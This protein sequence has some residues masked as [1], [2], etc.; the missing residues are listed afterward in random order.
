MN[1]D[2]KAS[3]LRIQRLRKQQNLTQEQLATKL[4]IAISTLG[5]IERGQQGFSLDLAIEI[6]LHFEVSLDYILLGREIQTD[7]FKRQIILIF[8]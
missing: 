3:G 2:T 8:N 1:Y 5:K 7:A 4:N 6:A